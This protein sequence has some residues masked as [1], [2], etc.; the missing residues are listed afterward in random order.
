MDHSLVEA[1]GFDKRQAAG[2]GEFCA[3]SVTSVPLVRL[4]GGG[5]TKT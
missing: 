2:G 4:F 3:Y 5:P 1:L